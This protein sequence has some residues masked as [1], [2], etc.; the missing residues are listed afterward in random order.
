M[1]L[2][3]LGS[4]REALSGSVKTDYLT[5]S[6][7]PQHRLPASRMP[8]EWKLAIGML[9]VSTLL[10]SGFADTVRVQLLRLGSQRVIFVVIG[11]ILG[12]GWYATAF[13]GFL[14]GAT[15]IASRRLPEIRAAEWSLKGILAIAP[16]GA[17]VGL[18]YGWPLT[19]VSGDLF[20]LTLLPITYFALVRRSVS[21]VRAVFRWLYIVALIFASLALLLTV[22]KNVIEGARLKLSFGGFMFPLLYI[23]LKERAH[24]VELLLVPAF[25]IGAVLT[26]KRGVWAAVLIAVVYSAVAKPWFRGLWRVLLAIA[27]AGCVILLVK[28]ERPAYYESASYALSA[29]WEETMV[30]VS[31]ARGGDLDP[32]AGG[33]AAE[34]AGV[35]RMIAAEGSLGNVLLGF[36][37]GT[38]IKAPGG[39]TRHH[40]HSTPGAFLARTGLIGTLLWLTFSVSIL[41]YLLRQLRRA[42]NGWYRT[43]WLLWIGLWSFGLLSS[44]KSQGFWG[45]SGLLVAYVVHLGE[46][47]LPGHRPTGGGL[48]SGR[49][50]LS[51]FGAPAL[52]APGR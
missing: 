42:D 13:V 43:Q 37:L 24:L 8:L 41:L 20:L 27:L 39:R 10:K 17:A 11:V 3:P 16:F 52:G 14:G 50:L 1:W 12:V 22:K 2:R 19:Y 48:Q 23:L 21:N 15:H 35:V 51:A 6:A 32:T 33:R 7:S 46:G 28:A 38:I 26:T 49:G 44:L 18:V 34:L 45:E 25:V 29:R 36:G 4:G 31:I 40:I 9:V 5:R 47:R 30:D